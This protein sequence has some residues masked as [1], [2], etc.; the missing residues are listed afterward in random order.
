MSLQNQIFTP[1]QN[2]LLGRLHNTGISKEDA[3][4]C[5]NQL[6][7]IEANHEVRIMKIIQNRINV[8]SLNFMKNY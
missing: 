1:E 8:Y 3:H 5:C 4:D 6:D 2:K 7:E